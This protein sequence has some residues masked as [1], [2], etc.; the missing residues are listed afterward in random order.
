M[1][2]KFLHKLPMEEALEIYNKLLA[3][4]PKCVDGTHYGQCSKVTS[5][6]YCDDGELVDKAECVAGT[7]EECVFPL[8]LPC[9]LAK[10]PEPTGEC[11]IKSIEWLDDYLKEGE[12][13]RFEVV[14][15][16]CIGETFTLKIYEDDLI[17]DDFIES[18]EITLGGNVH[19]WHWMSLWV[20]DW[21]G[22]PEYILV[23][24]GVQTSTSLK[25][26]QTMDGECMDTCTSKG[27][28]CG[29]HQIC[30]KQTS[31]GSC[32]TGET[33]NILLGKCETDTPD[34]TP[35]CAGKICGSDGC[36]GSCGSCGGACVEGYCS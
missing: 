17:G 24:D 34:C 6:K 13:A 4:Y 16:N 10:E 21:F 5:G 18:E 12:E 30:R 19:M 22:D 1:N 3:G 9:K 7:G 25:V 23:I 27:Y 35:D 31:C 29:S 2:F 15:K 26:S 28:D 14:S 33:C 36:T 32:P 20:K 8:K 11:K